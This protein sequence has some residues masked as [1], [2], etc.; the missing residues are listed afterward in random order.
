VVI[1]VFQRLIEFW[2]NEF[3]C[4]IQLR[5]LFSCENVE[6]KQKIIAAHFCPEMLYSD[7]GELGSGLARDVLSGE[8]KAVPSP[9][10]FAVGIECDTLSGLNGQSEVGEQVCETGSGKTGSTAKSTMSF[11][12]R[13]RPIIVIL[14]NVKNLGAAG[15]SGSMPCRATDLEILITKLNLMG[16]VVVWQTLRATEF[17]VPQS[18]ERIYIIAFLAKSEG[19]L[20]MQVPSNKDDD[21]PDLPAWWHDVGQLIREMKIEPLPIEAFLLNEDDDRLGAWARHRE[22]ST[23]GASEKAKAKAAKL[24]KTTEVDHIQAFEEAD[25]PWPPR[26]DAEFHERVYHLCP[27]MAQVVYFYEQMALRKLRKDSLSRNMQ[28]DKSVDFY[29]QRCSSLLLCVEAVWLR[30]MYISVE[31]GKSP[32]NFK[33]QVGDINMSMNWCRF[34][35]DSIPCLVGSSRMW[36]LQAPDT[37]NRG[38]KLDDDVYKRLDG[39]DMIGEE[40]LNFQCFPEQALQRDFMA[41]LSPR[42]A[43]DLAGNAFCGAKCVAIVTAALCFCPWEKSLSVQ[44]RL[45]A[46]PEVADESVSSSDSMEDGESQGEGP[47]LVS[48]SDDSL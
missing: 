5:H 16:Y 19:T 31:E 38:E 2:N 37:H 17:G 4:D 25:L 48:G 8:M 23:A 1:I 3:H 7:I 35:A 6:M 26:W 42:D 15:G 11:I 36:V 29:A 28:C 14:E 12:E 9:H 46:S 13:A 33:M 43:M 40:A 39:R 27:R 10:C 22:A 47:E 24:E 41:Q 44:S 30:T 21:P 20:L 18:R 45:M 32:A 34:L